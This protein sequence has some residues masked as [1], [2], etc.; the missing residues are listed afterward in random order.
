MFKIQSVFLDAISQH[1]AEHPVRTRGLR[2]AAE[3]ARTQGR[4]SSSQTWR[5][6]ALAV[7]KA[8]CMNHLA[9]SSPLPVHR[10]RNPRPRRMNQALQQGVRNPGVEPTHASARKSLYF[11]A[12]VQLTRAAEDKHCG[13]AGSRCACQSLL[14]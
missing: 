10:M 12:V 1:F 4:Q 7:C 2:E 11:C 14:P 3:A 9:Q 6:W 13:A 8:C 5:H